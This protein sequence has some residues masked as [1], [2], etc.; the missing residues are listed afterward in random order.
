MN[1]NFIITALENN[2]NYLF[3]LSEKELA[4]KGAKKMIVDEKPGYPCRVSLADAEIG[5]E[6]VLFPFQ[7][8]KTNSPFQS[9]GPIFVRKNAKTSTLEVN[10]IPEFLLHRFLS[11]RA[12]D[13][14]GMM[15]ETG[16]CQGTEL[17]DKLQSY[18]KNINVS[19][20]QIHNAGP[21]CYDCQV[22]RID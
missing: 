12:Y 17:K 6:V 19:Y 3:D 8:L 11:I 10:I 14:N 1:T 21:G 9:S 20:I 13:T 16:T 22:N 2:F 18:F 15:V 7:H 5:E 4:A